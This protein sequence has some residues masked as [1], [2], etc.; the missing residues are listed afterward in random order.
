MCDLELK[1]PIQTMSTFLFL[2]HVTRTTKIMTIQ[3]QKLNKNWISRN[4][5]TKII[6]PLT[7]CPSVSSYV[8]ISIRLANQMCGKL[9]KYLTWPC[10]KIF[11]FN[12]EEMSKSGQVWKLCIDPFQCWIGCQYQPNG[13]AGLI[14]I[15]KNAY[16]PTLVLQNSTTSCWIVNSP[17]RSD[18]LFKLLLLVLDKFN[19]KQ[20]SSS[21]FSSVLTFTFKCLQFCVFD[22][23]MKHGSA[24][25][26]F[27]L[28][29]QSK[30]KCWQQMVANSWHLINFS[31]I[32]HQI[33]IKFRLW[34]LR[35][36]LLTR[37]F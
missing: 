9:R 36:E 35:S 37:F 13:R 18:I 10:A 6:Q 26:K 20:F 27:F 16:L 5:W 28:M 29:F 25:H 12:H 31:S 2:F 21:S 7:P 22:Q 15:I 14:K 17:T 19:N 33:F 34:L 30:L 3:F 11:Q 24:F 23:L 8:R 4:R 32:F 1:G